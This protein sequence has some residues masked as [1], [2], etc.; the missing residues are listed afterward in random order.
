MVVMPYILFSEQEVVHIRD[1]IASVVD[2]WYGS[3]FGA[4]SS[5]FSLLVQS[6]QNKESLEASW[7]QSE[8]EVQFSTTIR[9]KSSLVKISADSSEWL[10]G[11]G[12]QSLMDQKVHKGLAVHADEAAIVLNALAQ[13]FVNTISNIEPQLGTTSALS[14]SEFLHRSTIK[15]AGILFFSTK[16]HGLLI[17]LLMEGKQFKAGQQAS[18][19]AVRVREIQNR[20]SACAK[21]STNLSAFLGTVDLT[22]GDL[23]KLS[24]GDIIKLDAS[25]TDSVSLAFSTG[26]AICSGRL[27]VSDD[28]KALRIAG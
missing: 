18:N 22:I 4:I 3:I 9:S 19:D 24:A 5:E 2:K 7:V 6:Y 17:Q 16:S 10:S 27:G 13:D 21:V 25:I 15:G 26:R 14:D 1:S 12:L 8:L 28:H 23:S 11:L 20:L